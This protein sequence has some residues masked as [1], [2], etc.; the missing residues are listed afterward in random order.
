MR[1]AARRR[2]NLTTIRK[3]DLTSTKSHFVRPCVWRKHSTRFSPC[4][5]GSY[6]PTSKD[7]RFTSELFLLVQLPV[8]ADESVFLFTGGTLHDLFRF[9]SHWEFSPL[10][11]VPSLGR[12]YFCMSFSAFTASGS[13]LLFCLIHR[14]DS[15]V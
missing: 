14:W 5:E 8:T 2:P 12:L 7:L 10:L 1:F 4:H 11:L 15:L 9:H 13:L 3:D 6:L